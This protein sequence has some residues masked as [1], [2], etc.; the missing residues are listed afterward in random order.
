MTAAVSIVFFSLLLWE[1][2]NY[3]LSELESDAICSCTADNDPLIKVY[4]MGDLQ[5]YR[6]DPANYRISSLFN[7]L[8]IGDPDDC[9]TDMF[10]ILPGVIL[11]A[12]SSVDYLF[13]CHG[14]HDTL[15]Q[16]DDLSGRIDYATLKALREHED[17]RVNELQELLAKSQSEL[18]RELS[19][20]KNKKGRTGSKGAL[21]G[22]SKMTPLA[23]I[24]AEKNF[25]F[26]IV[27]DDNTAIPVHSIVLKAQW[28]FFKA[29]VENGTVDKTIHNRRLKL[30]YP[31]SW[32][33]PL[34]SYFYAEKLDF[35][36]YVATGLLGLARLY[37][38]PS[39]EAIVVYKI[40]QEPL[41]M[42]KCL[43]G[44]RRAHEYNLREMQIYFATFY[45]KNQSQVREV[46]HLLA[47]LTQQEAVQLMVD[48][49]EAN[50]P[51]LN[52]RESSFPP[53]DI[54]I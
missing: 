19:R 42:D 29:I 49:G 28:P 3:S 51:L 24:R 21:N 37:D 46:T 23:L 8:K 53:S 33:E 6:Y 2:M 1:T 12:S 54:S 14:W 38:L 45:A 34:V 7:G 35:T 31:T 52:A 44:W 27:S 10:A 4:F 43:T 18:E 47:D 50:G 17:S 5:M 36:F 41:D 25:D 40:K 48:C 20:P 32:L 15:L 11:A 22:P 16:L 26:E 30:P 13:S 39:L 9:I